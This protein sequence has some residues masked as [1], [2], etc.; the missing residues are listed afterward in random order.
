MSLLILTTQ[1]TNANDNLV[2]NITYNIVTYTTCS[3]NTDTTYY[4]NSRISNSCWRNFEP[5]FPIDNQYSILTFIVG[6]FT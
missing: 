2:I 3:I 6:H 5:A 4:Y 1:I